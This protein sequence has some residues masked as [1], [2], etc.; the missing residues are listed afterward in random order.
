[1]EINEERQNVKQPIIS[2]IIP[3]YNSEKYLKK[4]IESLL[5]QTFKSFELLLVNDCSSDNSAGICDDY[6]ITD[7]RIRVF[8]RSS[9]AG[10]SAT[11]NYGLGNAR[12]DYICF[13]DSDDYVGPNFLL[14][15]YKNRIDG[16]EGMIIQGFNCSY[17]NS[18]A[19]IYTLKA[20]LLKGADLKKAITDYKIFSYGYPCMKMYS[21]SMLDKHGIRFDTNIHLFE[22]TIF[23]LECLLKADYVNFVESVNYFY[24]KDNIE[25]LSKKRYCL[26]TEVYLF[27]KFLQIIEEVAIKFNLNY[28]ELE[29]NANAVANR[30]IYRMIESVYKNSNPFSQSERLFY[31]NKIATNGDNIQRL[32]SL[33]HR[34]MKYRIIRHLF[35]SNKLRVLDTYLM[36]LRLIYP[37]RKLFKSLKEF[38]NRVTYWLSVKKTPTVV[39]IGIK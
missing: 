22:D 8:H 39:T 29:Q 18:M 13:V 2:V 31:L 21:R 12:G 5:H 11:R 25:C 23:T 32:K 17:K 14:D 24:I 27:E 1:M 35:I 30:L 4:C 26:N 9:N 38:K 19:I 7:C 10:V 34:T 33:S 3:I 36:F 28:D 6:A 20:A 16:K 37:I 15:F